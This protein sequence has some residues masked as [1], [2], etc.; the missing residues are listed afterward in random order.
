MIIKNSIQETTGTN[1]NI[2]QSLYQ[3]IFYNTSTGVVSPF[4]FNAPMYTTFGGTKDYYGQNPLAI[5][6]NL[7]DPFIRFTFTANTGSLSADTIV[8]HDIY[9]IDWELYNNV[10]SGF[11]MKLDEFDGTSDFSTETIEEIDELTGEVRLKTINRSLRQT[12]TKTKSERHPSNLGSDGDN[13]KILKPTISNIQDAFITPILTITASTSGITTGVYDLVIEQF[14]KD[15]NF[16]KYKTELFQDKSQYIIDTNFLFKTEIN[17]E[18][19]DFVTI[20]NGNIISQDYSL[21]NSGATSSNLETV[22]SGQFSGVSFVGGEFFSYLKVPDKPIIEYPSPTGQTNTFTP[23]VFWTN[24]EGAD[25]YQ[26]QVNYDI[27]DTGFTGTVFTYIVPK[28][29]EYKEVSTSKIKG[30]DTEFT[31]TKTIR[32]YQISLKSNKCLLYRVGNVKFIKNIFGVKQSVVTFSENNEMCTQTTPIKSYVYTE[33]DSPFVSKL[34]GLTT[35]PS[36]TYET[37]LS[38]YILSGV[39]VGSIVSGATIQLVYPN[40]NFVTTTTDIVGNFLFTSLETGNYTLNTS[41]RGYAS[42]SVPISI[43]S[44]TNIT[45]ELQI[46]WDNIYDIWAIKE[47]DIIKY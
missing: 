35:P 47:N 7:V 2:A 42:D 37:P 30:P 27:A 28:L 8:R 40:S 9:R 33:N 38:E 21:M 36:L 31:S 4:I 24:G 3:N 5:F 41:Y 6:T 29:D 19:T 32:K 13:T 16:S 39:V 43:T 25:E 34:S 15:V 11:D 18:L 14:I 20:S 17:T 1:D 45:V 44:D 22:N 12:S 10:Q 23:E 46:Q 26:V